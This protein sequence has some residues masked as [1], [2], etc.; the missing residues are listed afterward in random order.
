V[1]AVIEAEKGGIYRSDDGG[2]SWHLT[3]DDHRFRQRAW[4]YSH[5]FADPQIG[6]HGVHPEHR[7]VS[8]Q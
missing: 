2:D 6:G 8:V 1:W 5:I 3:T 4:Y 7:G